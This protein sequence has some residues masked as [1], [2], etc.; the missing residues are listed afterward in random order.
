[1]GA[2]INS[3]CKANLIKLNTNKTEAVSFSTSC[4]PHTTLLI[5]S[6]TIH[7]QPQIKC[8]GIWWQ[9]DLSPNRSVE[10]NI[11]KA[12]RAFLP[13]AQFGTFHGKLNSLSSRNIFE[14]FVIPVLY[15]CEMWILTPSLVTKLEKFQSE[16]GRRILCLSKH[17]AD[18]APLIGLHLPSMKAHI[19]LRKLNLLAKLLSSTDN[20]LSATSF[21]I[22]AADNVTLVQQCLG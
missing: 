20:T 12:H 6:D 7:S 3:F 19:L 1:M 13:Q 11:A 17:H 14:I 9:H 4:P 8:L 18:L 5:A 10:D 21:R 15:G 22:L 16:I 2:C